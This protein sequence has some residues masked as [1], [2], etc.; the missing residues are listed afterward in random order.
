MKSCPHT[1]RN[2]VV[3]QL[4]PQLELDTG[5]PHDGRVDNATYPHDGRADNAAY[6]HD[7][8]ANNAA[9]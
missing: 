7:R 1:L 4:V 3:T 8:H 9:Y 6:P 5:Y 2:N